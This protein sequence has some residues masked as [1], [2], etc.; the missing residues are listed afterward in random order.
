[1]RKKYGETPTPA[2]EKQILQEMTAFRA[3]AQKSASK[4]LRALLTPAQR[5]KLDILEAPPTIRV[6]PGKP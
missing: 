1:M 5:K 3:E 6:R 2:Q 4:E